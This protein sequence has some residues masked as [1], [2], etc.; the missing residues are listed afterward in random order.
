MT[1]NAQKFM[2]SERFL[3]NNII[4]KATKIYQTIFESHPTYLQSLNE[5]ALINESIQNVK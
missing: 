1:I 5:I 3:K 2:I 4:N